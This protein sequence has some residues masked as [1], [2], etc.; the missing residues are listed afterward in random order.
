MSE[1]PCLDP[2]VMAEVLVDRDILS[3][4]ED[5]ERL[6][7]GAHDVCAGQQR[8]AH[9]APIRHVR[10]LLDPGQADVTNLEHVGIVKSAGLRNGGHV[11]LSVDVAL[12][13]RPGVLDVAFRTPQVGH[14]A[15][16]FAASGWVSAV[17][18][19]PDDGPGIEKRFA[20]IKV[21]LVCGWE[22]RREHLKRNECGSERGSLSVAGQPMFVQT[23][24]CGHGI[25]IKRTGGGGVSQA[26][27]PQGTY[28]PVSL[29]HFSNPFLKRTHDLS[30][31]PGPALGQ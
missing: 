2:V 17:L 26:R 28:R 22:E 8:R 20:E 9:D 27:G 24:S 29:K 4:G 11:V 15:D 16:P 6:G 7:R 21:F 3:G 5:R 14:G 12:D 23:S 10:P 1:L 31:T 25:S 30:G 18:D 19:R 13:R